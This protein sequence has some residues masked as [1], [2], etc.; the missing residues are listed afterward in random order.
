MRDGLDEVRA[1]LPGVELR[2][3]G[4]LAGGSSRSVVRRVG[5]DA[6]TLIVKT[7]LG[8]ARGWLRESAALSVMPTDAP[9]PRLIAS[10]QVPP[11]VVM[12]DLGGGASVADALLGQD[13]AVAAEAVHD[14]ARAL[15][16]LHRTTAGSRAAFQAALDARSGDAPVRG[17]T[18]RDELD[19][20]WPV[21]ERYCAELGVEVP[22]S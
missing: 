2:Q 3:L 8:E 17:S 14:W 9:A 13:A 16:A 21:L 7:F 4:V 22:G 5:A 18:L 20:A 1:L 12:A 15:A 11:I 10:G 19:E 6:G